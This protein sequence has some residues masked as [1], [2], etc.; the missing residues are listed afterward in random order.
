MGFLDEIKQ[1]VP[2]QVRPVSREP[3]YLEAVVTVRDMGV[4]EGILTR[5]LGEAHKMPGQAI[6]FDE[7]IRTVVDAVGGLMI[8]QTLFY[9]KE[10][11]KILYAMLWPWQSDPNR[12]TLKAG[13]VPE[14]T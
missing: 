14:K 11:G 2:L 3:D 12:I 1:N 9:R 7:E 4:L 5:H 13:V 10:A 6:L 8:Q